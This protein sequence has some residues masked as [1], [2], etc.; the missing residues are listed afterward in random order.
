MKSFGIRVLPGLNKKNCIPWLFARLICEIN[1]I[2]EN[3]IRKNIDHSPG[4]FCAVRMQSV[5]LV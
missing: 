5:E 3:L 4:V 1:K 2:I